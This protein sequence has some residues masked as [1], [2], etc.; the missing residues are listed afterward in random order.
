MLVSGYFYIVFLWKDE[1]T[2]R[3]HTDCKKTKK[4]HSSEKRHFVSIMFVNEKKKSV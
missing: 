2:F 1:K 4:K 3:G